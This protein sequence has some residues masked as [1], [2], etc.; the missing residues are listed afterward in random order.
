VKS[1][2][3]NKNWSDESLMVAVRDADNHEALQVLYERY[4]SRLFG[5]IFRMLNHTESSK[6]VLQDVFIKVYQNRSKFDE[7]HRFY[8]WLFTIAR[9]TTIRAIHS[10]STVPIADHQRGLATDRDAAFHLETA[11]LGQQIEKAIQQLKTGHREIV[12]MRFVHKMKIAEIAQIVDCSEGTIKSR[13][14][15][16]TQ[17]LTQL[18]KEEYTNI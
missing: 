10:V 13:L 1:K 9:N 7:K 6:D 11:E 14:F 12:I 15:Y 3:I 18:L 4:Q 5:F 8:S 16:A 2:P 17:Q